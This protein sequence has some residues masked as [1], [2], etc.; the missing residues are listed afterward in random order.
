MCG[1]A[2]HSAATVRPQ[3]AN[4]RSSLARRARVDPLQSFANIPQCGPQK[5]NSLA[6]VAKAVEACAIYRAY[7]TGGLLC[8]PVD[9]MWPNRSLT[10]LSAISRNINAHSR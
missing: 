6:C 8:D 1:T 3:T 9:G 7:F 5:L 4:D 2:D 10:V